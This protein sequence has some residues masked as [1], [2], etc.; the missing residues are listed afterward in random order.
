MKK[1]KTFAIPIVAV[2]LI[3]VATTTTKAEAAKKSA[4]QKTFV[5][6]AA[7]DTEAISNDAAIVGS[8]AVS[9]LRQSENA[10]KKNRIASNVQATESGGA[11]IT[12]VPIAVTAGSTIESAIPKTAPK[13]E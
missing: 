12:A 4:A 7:N 10:A 6:H 3:L 13:L 11:V 8:D 5:T 9:V 2:A 1:L